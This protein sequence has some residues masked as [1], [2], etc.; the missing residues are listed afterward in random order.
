MSK[1]KV[2]TLNEKIRVLEV[3]KSKSA[4]KFNREWVWSRKNPFSVQTIYIVF[5]IRENKY[6]LF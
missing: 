2:L 3:S 5:R 4:R 6:N 1:R